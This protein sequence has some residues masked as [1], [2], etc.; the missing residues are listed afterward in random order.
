[1]DNMYDNVVLFLIII[2][3]RM[4]TIIENIM[5]IESSKDFTCIES[6]NCE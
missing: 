6:H 5:Y 3:R 1:M 4:K 2:S